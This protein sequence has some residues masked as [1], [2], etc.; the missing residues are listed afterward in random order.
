MN[1]TEQAHVEIPTRTWKPWE[2]FKQ[3]LHG[4]ILALQALID[5]LITGIV[6]V[7]GF[8]LPVL[9][10]LAIILW[11]IRLTWRRFRR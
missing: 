7:I 5:I 8:L 6:F 10:V 11:L 3:S 2:T 9:L 4:L 1:L